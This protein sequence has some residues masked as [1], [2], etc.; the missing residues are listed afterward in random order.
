MKADK[1]KSIMVVRSSVVEH[2]GDTVG[3]I[4]LLAVTLWEMPFF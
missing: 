1:V 3:R 4:S 2:F